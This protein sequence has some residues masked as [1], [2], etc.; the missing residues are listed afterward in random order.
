LQVFR[1]KETVLDSRRIF[2][3]IKIAAVLMVL[4]FV[5]SEKTEPKFLIIGAVSSLIIAILCSR[6]LCMK[7][8][9]TDR[10]YYYTDANPLRMTRYFLWLLVQIVKSACYVSGISLSDK[11]KVEPS[12]AY[13]RA[14]YDSPFARAL[15]ANS[16]TLT[17]GTITIDITD[18]GVYSVHALTEELR[19]GLLD[20]S[21]Q[22]KVAWA[23]GEDIDFMPPSESEVSHHLRI[24]SYVTEPMKYRARRKRR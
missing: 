3:I 4:W 20:G 10:I 12:V 13:F 11:S 17:P 14:D 16:I 15:L 18:D 19:E 21:M 5:M 7:G 22:K 23:Y 2:S 8:C 1:K 24:D 9:R 6:T